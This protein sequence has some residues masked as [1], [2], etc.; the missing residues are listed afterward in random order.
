M[1]VDALLHKPAWLSL[2]F[3]DVREDLQVTL[4]DGKRLALIRFSPD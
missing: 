1:G 3:K 4:D 2:T